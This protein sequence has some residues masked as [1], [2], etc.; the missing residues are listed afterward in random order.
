MKSLLLF[1]LLSLLQNPSD[2]KGVEDIII[3]NRESIKSSHVVFQ[4]ETKT[5]ENGKEYSNSTGT[6]EVWNS[7]TRMRMDRT[8][9]GPRVNRSGIRE[10]DSIN[11][12]LK[13]SYLWFDEKTSGYITKTQQGKHQMNPKMLDIKLLGLRSTTMHYIVYGKVTYNEYLKSFSKDAKISYENDVDGKRICIVTSVLPSSSQIKMILDVEKSFSPRMIETLYKSD[14]QLTQSKSEFKYSIYNGIYFPSEVWTYRKEDEGN[15][16]AH[17]TNEIIK[18]KVVEF[19]QKI[20]SDVFTLEGMGMKP[21]HSLLDLDSK[22][23][24]TFQMDKMPKNVMPKT[25]EPK[26]PTPVLPDGQT[27][28]SRFWV[29]VVAISSLVSLVLLYLIFFRK[30][31]GT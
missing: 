9:E 5:T 25:Y 1:F 23:F 18:M 15:S 24:I 28:D 19:N 27:Q 10:V 4:I 17:V 16:I 30:S 3:K 22:A 20:S 14:G 2:F 8:L 29:Y 12:D 6:Y 26:M 21:G 13:G 7:G 11:H 31:R